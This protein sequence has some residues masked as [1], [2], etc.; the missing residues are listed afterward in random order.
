MTS[1]VSRSCEYHTDDRTIRLI[2]IP[3]LGEDIWRSSGASHLSSFSPNLTRGLAP[4]YDTPM[5]RWHHAFT[6]NKTSPGFEPKPYGT[7]VSGPNHYTG[8]ATRGKLKYRTER[9]ISVVL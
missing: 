7:A 9:V 2:S 4:I 6:N 8:W 3:N 1:V 5:P